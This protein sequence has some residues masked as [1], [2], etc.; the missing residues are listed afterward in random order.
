MSFRR[1]RSSSTYY[2][3]PHDTAKTARGKSTYSA[4]PLLPEMPSLNCDLRPLLPFSPNGRSSLVGG[5]ISSA[6]NVACC[7]RNGQVDTDDL[8]R[9]HNTCS[10]AETRSVW[11][12]I[13]NADVNHTAGATRVYQRRS[14]FPGPHP[15]YMLT[16]SI[17]SVQ[18]IYLVQLQA[19]TP[20][21]TSS[22][23][24]V[25]PVHVYK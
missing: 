5:C 7:M 18:Y 15:L 20:V 17:S 21:Y 6:G 12:L 14:P 3:L 19:L 2:W 24:S 4:L 16:A 10:Y 1:T 8:S 9:L 25:Q 22:V 13:R 11:H 23:Y